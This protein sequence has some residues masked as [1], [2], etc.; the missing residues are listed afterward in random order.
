MKRIEYNGEEEWR[1]ITDK[2]KISFPVISAI[3]MGYKIDICHE[4]KL[5]ELCEKQKLSLYKQ[6]LNTI[7][8]Y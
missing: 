6:Y 5:K 3:Y 2:N 8:I 7:A 1:I 4:Q